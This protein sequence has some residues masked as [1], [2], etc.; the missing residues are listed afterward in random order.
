M[1]SFGGKNGKTKGRPYI[2]LFQKSLVVLTQLFSTLNEAAY[3][4]N[5]NDATDQPFTCPAGL[6]V[7]CGQVATL[8]GF[9]PVTQC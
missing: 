5:L 1:I 3:T 6:S 4:R 2:D 7:G 8:T 9:H